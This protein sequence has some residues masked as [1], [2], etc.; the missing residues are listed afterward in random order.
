MR[1]TAVRG[2]DDYTGANYETARQLDA[3]YSRPWEQAF[4]GGEVT[5]GRDVFGDSYTRVG[6]FIRF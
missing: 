2:N 5:V 3:R 6:A 4:V 1:V